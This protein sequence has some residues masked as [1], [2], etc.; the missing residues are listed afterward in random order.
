MFCYSL[1]PDMKS[2][3]FMGVPNF[4]PQFID[5]KQGQRRMKILKRLA[6]RLFGSLKQARVEKHKGNMR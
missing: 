6:L 5:P 3:K 1:P 2:I 4:L